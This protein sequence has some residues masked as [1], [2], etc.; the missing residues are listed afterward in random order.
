MNAPSCK[1]VVL[2]VLDGWGY[3]E[4]PEHNAILNARIPTLDHLWRDYPHLLIRCS[5]TDVG[6]P[7]GR[8]GGAGGGRRGRGA[9]RGGG[10]EGARGGRA[11][12]RGAGGAG[13]ARADAGEAAV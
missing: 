10:R 5:G 3:S 11:G 2:L 13:R 4:Q 1:P 9:G 8:G 12:G 7:A 6:L